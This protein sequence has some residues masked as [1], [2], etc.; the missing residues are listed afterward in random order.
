ML[1][2]LFFYSNVLAGHAA[3]KGF[4]EQRQAA[5]KERSQVS[6]P[7]QLLAQLP[8]AR[9]VRFGAPAGFTNLLLREPIS[10]RPNPSSF[11]KRLSK[12]VLPY[13]YVK[14]AY[15]ST[16][17]GAPVLIHVQDL[18]NHA[19]AQRNVAGFLRDLRRDLGVNLVGLEGAAGAF[20]LEPY[21]QYPDLDIVRS[22]ADSFLE[23]GSIGGPEYDGIVSENPP[24][25]WGIEEGSLYAENVQALKEASL[26][27]KTAEDVLNRLSRSLDVL[28]D[29]VYSPELQQFDRR[30]VAYHEKGEGLGAYVRFLLAGTSSSQWP[31]LRRL[32]EAVSWEEKIDFKAVELDRKRF[33][34]DLARRLNDEA[35][36]KLIRQSVD[37]RSG[38]ITNGDFYR[39]LE[40]LCREN[41]IDL[42]VYGRMEPYIRYVFLTE[43]IERDKLFSELARLEGEAQGASVKTPE[44]KKLAEAVRDHA[45]LSKLFRHKM[46]P[47]DWGAFQARRRN[48]LDISLTMR[49]LAAEAAL[50]SAPSSKEL[51]SLLGPYERFCSSALQR[52]DAFVRNL[53]DKMTSEKATS[54]VLVAGGFHTDGLSRLLREKN[55]SY[56]VVTPRIT[57]IPENGNAYL[58]VFSRDPLPL[59]RLFAGEPI[60]LAP[61]RLLAES[62]RNAAEAPP[63][64]WRRAATME[65]IFAVLF[66]G[67]KIA[68]AEFDG[69]LPRKELKALA[70]RVLAESERL[71][72]RFRTLE[73]LSLSYRKTLEQRGLYF[74]LDGEMRQRRG[75]TSHLCVVATTKEKEEAA[76]SV[77]EEAAEGKGRPAGR[78]ELDNG[79]VFLFYQNEGGFAL[80]LR[81]LF[82]RMVEPLRSPE[83]ESA[84]SV[85]RYQDLLAQGMPDE[86]IQRQIR[87]LHASVGWSRFDDAFENMANDPDHTILLAMN[88]RGEI[89]GYAS[90]VG[91][92]L[93]FTAVRK[94]SQREGIGERLFDEAV[95]ETRK[96]GHRRISLDYRLEGAQARFYQSLAWKYPVISLDDAPR[97]PGGELW[98]H[99]VFDISEGP[100]R[101][102]REP[103]PGGWETSSHRLVL[104]GD[105]ARALTEGDRQLLQLIIDANLDEQ[106]RLMDEANRGRASPKV[107]IAQWEDRREHP[108]VDEGRTIYLALEN[109]VTV[110]AGRNSEPRTIRMLR[111][112]GVR[113]RTGADGNVSLY[114]PGKTGHVPRAMNVDENGNVFVAKGSDEPFGG[115]ALHSSAK[116]YHAMRECL[117]AGIPADFPVG[118]GFYKNRWFTGRSKKRVP[119]AF[120]IAGLESEDRRL[121]VLPQSVLTESGRR[122][123][124]VRLGVVRYRPSGFEPLNDEDETLM[125]RRL[126]K[127]LRRFHDAG[128][129]HRYPHMM[130]M[131]FRGGQTDRPEVILRDFESVV[132]RSDLPGAGDG[133]ARVEGAYRYL[134][135]S[136]LIF[137]FFQQGPRFLDDE[138]P[139]PDAR[140]LIPHFFEGYFPEFAGQ[141]G[142]PEMV[143]QMSDDTFVETTERLSGENQWETLDKVS[144]NESEA[145]FVG[146]LMGPLYRVSR[147]AREEEV[148][149]GMRFL[150]R[151]SRRMSIQREMKKSA[152]R[153]T[154]GMARSLW[155]VL[156]GLTHPL[157]TPVTETLVLAWALS[158][159]APSGWAWVLAGALFALIHPDNYDVK[160]WRKGEITAAQFW[161]RASARAGWRFA[162]GLA[163]AYPLVFSSAP[164]SGM[165]WSAA[166]HLVW[167]GTWLVKEWLSKKKTRG[168]GEPLFFESFRPLA[169]R[170]GKT[171]DSGR[172]PPLGKAEREK[173][174]Q[175]FVVTQSFE[176]SW[177]LLMTWNYLQLLENNFPNAQITI[178]PS[179][180]RLFRCLKFG[181]RVKVTMNSDFLK[182]EQ[183]PDETLVIYGGYSSESLGS[184]LNNKKTL[185]IDTDYARYFP[186][187]ERN[188]KA[189]MTPVPLF[190][191]VPIF[192]TLARALRTL[193]FE[194]VQTD[195]PPVLKPADLSEQVLKKIT[196]LETK[197]PPDRTVCFVNLMAGNGIWRNHWDDWERILDQLLSDPQICVVVNEGPQSWKNQPRSQ[198]ERTA[199]EE[200]RDVYDHYRPHL[201][202][203][204]LVEI[205]G[206]EGS[207]NDLI[208]VVAMMSMADVVITEH[209]GILH[210]ADWMRKPT[211]AFG[212]R[213]FGR[214]RMTRKGSYDL[215]YVR[216]R[217][218]ESVHRLSRGKPLSIPTYRWIETDD[219][220]LLQSARNWFEKKRRESDDI[221]GPM[222][223]AQ[224]IFYGVL[225][226][227]SHPLAAPFTETIGMAMALSLVSPAGWTWVLAGA[228]FALIHPD[229][230]D[231]LSWREI[232]GRVA[233]RFAGSLAVTYPLMFLSSPVS[234]LLWSAVIHLAWNG[235]WLVKEWRMMFSSFR[236]LSLFGSGT[237]PPAR[238]PPLAPE[239]RAVLGRLAKGTDK[240]RIAFCAAVGPWLEDP[241]HLSAL[242]DMAVDA[243][244]EKSVREAAIDALAPLAHREDIQRLLLEQLARPGDMDV[245]RKNCVQALAPH[246]SQETVRRGLRDHLDGEE[247]PTPALALMEALAP[248]AHEPEV[249]R[250]LL[251]SFSTRRHGIFVGTGAGAL[252]SQIHRPEVQAALFQELKTSPMAHIR[253]D[254][255]NAL[256]PVANLKE[257]R[258][259]LRDQLERETDFMTRP[260]I[261]KALFAHKRDRD[262]WEPLMRSED[263]LRHEEIVNALAPYAHELD[264]QQALLQLMREE[265]HEP[266]IGAIVKAVVPQSGM[267]VWRP[268]LGDY[269]PQVREAAIDALSPL[270]HGREV[271]RALQDRLR[272]ETDP[273]LRAEI[274]MI[275]VSQV[276]EEEV[277]RPLLND[278]DPN[279]QRL[280]GIN[281]LIPSVHRKETRETLMKH[282][283][284]GIDSAAVRGAVIRALVSQAREERDWRPL[285]ESSGL[286]LREAA[287]HAL[288]SRVHE[289]TVRR[290]LSDRLED[291]DISHVRRTIVNVL[292]GQADVDPVRE[293]LLKRWKQEPDPTV[294][295]AIANAL[296]SQAHRREVQE[297]LL[298]YLDSD[299]QAVRQAA[300]FALRRGG[301]GPDATANNLA[302]DSS[303][304]A[305]PA[306][307][308]HNWLVSLRATEHSKF[309]ARM[310]GVAFQRRVPQFA[311]SEKRSEAPVREDRFLIRPSDN[312]LWAGRTLRS[313]NVFY[314]VARSGERVE[315]LR[316]EAKLLNEHYP[317]ARAELVKAVLDGAPED[318]APD[319][320]RADG[321][322]KVLRYTMEDP[323]SFT[324]YPPDWH[325]GSLK[326]LKTWLGRT[327]KDLGTLAGRGWG[328]VGLLEFYHDINTARRYDLEK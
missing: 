166:I 83:G 174:R 187:Y 222:G 327:A 159:V 214:N 184:W 261:L 125:A 56:A 171:S 80:S 233:W 30:F 104:N 43:K 188:G 263:S 74:I 320:V 311:S 231:G 121:R 279:A 272:V 169:A 157:I 119:V 160:A 156:D 81:D 24:L 281:A 286:P 248:F 140:R 13:G 296:A 194:G 32:A 58:D 57:E 146:K 319:W 219:L 209:S 168:K 10:S 93:A 262:I 1:A 210:L 40:S 173:I 52:N 257:V 46:T 18:H 51:A 105:V 201:K 144:L 69:R 294:R 246:V 283:R 323:E 163:I 37:Y 237:P 141:P 274:A 22:L 196:E 153:S 75:R 54:A 220:N 207:E 41:K 39:F 310:N 182:R 148:A 314:K 306:Q 198:R 269:D 78:V 106:D 126:G 44:Q 91:D 326:Q 242:Q 136:R 193:G 215:L 277:W 312:P 164:L 304:F 211:L 267:E 307:S 17:P 258:A 116:E 298:R 7:N 124:E 177:P 324:T 212:H 208:R 143:R 9:A 109:P 120:V 181:P 165:A 240:E 29:A 192:V 151:L 23:D 216:D 21:R 206:G 200:V 50:P 92:Y 115:M 88:G 290:A 289:E 288:S 301:Y 154:A 101:V 131:G 86:E 189:W 27:A 45:L 302:K 68:R 8:E 149:R 328:Y 20:S 82:R 34:E 202:T 48:I 84:I 291:E 162:G 238:A 284:V 31:N 297:A 293:T 114:G 252:V 303:R 287:V 309:I 99:I 270:A 28:K 64:V 14:E 97:G 49:S 325:P 87:A 235:L 11:P 273:L 253:L 317:G 67:A 224:G 205:G 234:G 313:G 134:D 268:L 243:D 150:G 247:H 250:A 147:T 217:I 102:R 226:L 241:A 71:G 158:L 275:L 62:V 203:G 236:P 59:E 175:V 176:L 145:C 112:K 129:F 221:P 128:L 276:D 266:I 60:S 127:T 5:A 79:L 90:L 260:V 239:M 47:E 142:F 42:A 180:P 77:F 94:D 2:V 65:G 137:S 230:Y 25:L 19:Q 190:E 15:T 245:L 108:G 265:A 26:L 85:A 72:R 299:P 318:G 322:A 315:D 271:L 225:A 170:G 251:R 282:L 3:E 254:V 53:L 107:F 100:Q 191:R 110:K 186:A 167:N 152:S 33:V 249:L 111:L 197:I 280:A 161:T 98:K 118:R 229:N 227:L 195:T 38:R 244:A 95:A 185:M 76:K 89:A 61:E 139:P 66:P 223:T 130:N 6:T 172:S 199:Y 122:E 117:G 316:Q 135:I 255:V 103:L 16:M 228:L 264:V 35:L 138:D 218:V 259:A 70:G 123:H 295:A 132:W 4:W 179:D 36:T 133:L 63:S 308:H 73:H 113:L 232:A 155:N 292:A 300:A 178:H 204:R 96:M 278:R 12:I 256:A 183:N 55:V 213:R 321:P 305:A 285:L